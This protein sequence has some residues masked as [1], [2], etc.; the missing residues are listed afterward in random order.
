MPD[1]FDRQPGDGD[2]DRLVLL[3][4]M[5]QSDFDRF[6]HALESRPTREQLVA[7]SEELGNSPSYIETAVLLRIIGE[8]LVAPPDSSRE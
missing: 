4:P 6:V 2:A 5:P 3:N 1:S 8:R 7:M